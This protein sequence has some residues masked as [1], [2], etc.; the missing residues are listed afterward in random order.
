V[1]TVV[2]VSQYLH[3]T[4]RCCLCSCYTAVLAQYHNICVYYGC[5]TLVLHITF[6]DVAPLVAGTAAVNG[7]CHKMFRCFALGV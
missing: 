2:V 5:C 7:T 4:N 3:E 1:T 6:T